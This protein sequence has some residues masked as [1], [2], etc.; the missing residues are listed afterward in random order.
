VSEGSKEPDKVSTGITIKEGMQVLITATGNIWCGMAAQGCNDPYGWV[1]W[2]SSNY[3]D[4]PMPK[5]RIY[6]LIGYKKTG[7]S[8]SSGFWVSLFG[9]IFSLFSN[10]NKPVSYEPFFIGYDCFINN[11]DQ[12]EFELYLGINDNN[13]QNG[14]QCK[15][16]ATGDQKFHVTVSIVEE[17]ERV[18]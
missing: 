9:D 5:Q 15:S 4:F 3:D 1:G 11:V 17:L 14:D 6:S 7:G 18:S 2:K 8:N 16:T 13:I 12:E 10:K